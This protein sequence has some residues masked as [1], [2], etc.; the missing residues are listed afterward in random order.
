[1][2]LPEYYFRIRDNG[3]A[4]FRVDTE[5]RHRR[6]EMEP[7]AA[8]NIR[9]GDIRPHGSKTLSDADRAH[10]E[11][12]MTERRQTLAARDTDTAR[13]TVE[14]IN[15]TAHWVQSK[16]TD[17]SS[18]LHWRCTFTRQGCVGRSYIC[19]RGFFPGWGLK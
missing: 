2:E 14:Q 10:I 3:A 7:I 17:R 12:W 16:A 1:M 11:A 15:K 18:S 5:N 19:R 4:V 8:V 13:Q 6:I 9:T